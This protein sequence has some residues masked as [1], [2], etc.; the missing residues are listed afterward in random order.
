MARVSS[1]AMVSR[2]GDEA[3][4]IETSPISEVMRRSGLLV[5][6]ETI[7]EGGTAEIEQVVV[8]DR[9]DDEIKEDNSILSPSKPSHIEFG[10]STVTEEDLV[11]MKKL[12]YFGEEE[13]KLI[14]FAAEEVIPEPR[15]DEVVVF[16]NFF[17]AGLQFPLY[18]IIGEV[19]KR[20]EIYLHQLTLNAIV[21]LSVYI[22]ALQS[23]GKSANAE[24][25]SRVHE[26]H[27]QTKA[28]SMVFKKTLDVIIL[29]TGKTPRLR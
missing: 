19:L 3:E 13:S 5:P 8:E 23:Q 14:R 4:V 28:E 29:H 10:K 2:E 16:R 11:M 15:E 21:R 18:D 9:S 26:L 22:W 17:R 27:Y 1:T 7:A 24:G 25:F 20:F 6:E 12:D